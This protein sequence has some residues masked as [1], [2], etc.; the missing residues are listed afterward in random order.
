MLCHLPGHVKQAQGSE[1]VRMGPWR[2]S[3]R[4]PRAPAPLSTPKL[5]PKLCLSSGSAA[6]SS[7]RHAPKASLNGTE[8]TSVTYQQCVILQIVTQA[9]HEWA[10]PQK[11][12]QSEWL[13]VMLQRIKQQ[14]RVPSRHHTF[15]ICTQSQE[16]KLLAESIKK[17]RKGICRKFVLT[18]VNHFSLDKNQL[19]SQS[20]F[21]GSFQTAYDLQQ[22]CDLAVAHLKL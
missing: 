22:L 7:S 11:L 1:R 20:P 6:T 13:G 19:R 12:G 8:Q 4:T 2:S 3:H 15:Y 18:T 17:I 10:M 14:P 16:W 5:S 9:W 21:N